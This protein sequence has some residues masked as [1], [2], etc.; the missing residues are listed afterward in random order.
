MGLVCKA[1]SV[2]ID[3]NEIYPSEPEYFKKKNLSGCM[4]RIVWTE[5]PS[6]KVQKQSKTF[7][8]Q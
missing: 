3:N 7:L 1:P 5:D 8:K 4:N 6:E 2:S